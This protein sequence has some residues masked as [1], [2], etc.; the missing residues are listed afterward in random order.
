VITSR[1]HSAGK[2]QKSS[3]QTKFRELNLRST[4]LVYRSSVVDRDRLPAKKNEF[5]SA[6]SL[7][8]FVVWHHLKFQRQRT[9]R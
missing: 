2:A 3:H 8:P 9:A 4:N 6:T 5:I 1:L 7:T